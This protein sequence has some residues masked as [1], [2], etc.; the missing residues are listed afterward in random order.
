M[1][2]EQGKNQTQVQPGADYDLMHKMPSP[3]PPHAMSSAAL[4]SDPVQ[5]AGWPL[6]C[7]PP[8]QPHD[9]S[10]GKT[11]LR[12]EPADVAPVSWIQEEDPL[13]P[14]KLAPAGPTR[15]ST[16]HPPAGTWQSPVAPRATTSRAFWLQRDHLVVKTKPSSESSLAREGGTRMRSAGTRSAPQRRP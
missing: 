11:V 9:P 2:T 4:P 15:D 16:S 8:T 6:P 3:S 5:R 13:V 7:T 12:R 14:P 1:D 10:E